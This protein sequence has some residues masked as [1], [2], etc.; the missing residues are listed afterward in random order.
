MLLRWGIVEG[1][2]KL[3]ARE[4]QSIENSVGCS[5]GSWKIRVLKAVQMMEAWLVTFQREAKIL[6]G[7]MC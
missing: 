6:S 1:V 2:L 5:I 4:A 7:L 3:W